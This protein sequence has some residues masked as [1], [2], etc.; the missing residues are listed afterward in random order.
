MVS[1]VL[2]CRGA[3]RDGPREAVR[4]RTTS[5]DGAA[6]SDGRIRGGS[7]GS[8]SIRFENSV[9]ALTCGRL[10][11]SGC[12]S[13]AWRQIANRSTGPP[14][15]HSIHREHRVLADSPRAITE[16]QPRLH[17]PE[18]ALRAAG[19]Q[20]PSRTA[21][22]AGGGSRMGSWRADRSRRRPTARL[23]PPGRHRWWRKMWRASRSCGRAA[24]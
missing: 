24:A 18:V 20:I 5:R 6:S 2:S 22:P 17:R 12:R 7:R 8:E 1:V 9:D 19:M 23:R 14:Y 11:G 4:L 3:W 21:P 16:S 15:G 13:Q 10:G